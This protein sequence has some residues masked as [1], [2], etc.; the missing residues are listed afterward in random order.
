MTRHA[1]LAAAL[2]A[3]AGVLAVGA[4][5]WYA[6]SV[7]GAG[8]R[9]AALIVGIGDSVAAGTR[10]GG[11]NF[12]VEL[13]QSLHS[14]RGRA[15]TVVNFAV[16]GLT[17]RWL[18]RQVRLP[19][20]RGTLR[21]ADLV[22]VT[23]G[24]ND[25]SQRVLTTPDRWDAEV[26]RLRRRVGELL[27]HL[28]ASRGGAGEIMITGYWNVF[29]DGQRAQRLGDGHRVSSDEFT[30]R[31]NECLRAVASEHGAGFVDLYAPFKGRG[32]RDPSDLLASDGNH[33]NEAGHAVIA[34][35]IR[36]HRPVLGA[37]G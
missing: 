18:V 3:A 13:G 35:Q 24:A 30:R 23:I 5:R 19:G 25:F 21:R 33:P 11:T 29:T 16:P 20:V 9:G 1:G 34:E 36:R 10:S 31:V 17:T 14:E 12:L 8:R 27:G 2:G 15:I 26:A 32:D 28:Q 4:L 37:G 7:F 6:T 22:V